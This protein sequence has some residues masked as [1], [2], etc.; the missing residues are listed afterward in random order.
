MDTS[1]IPWVEKY[2][3]KK[4]QDLVLDKC[5]LTK[6]KKIVEE[7]NMPNLI[8]TGVPGIGKTTTILCIAKQLLGKYIEQG[9]LELNASDERGIKTVQESI[10][11]FCKK[12]FDLIDEKDRT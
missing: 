7:K 12:K 3:P 2:R 6:I 1:N 9:K 8:I 10:I 11:Y 5:I 4:I